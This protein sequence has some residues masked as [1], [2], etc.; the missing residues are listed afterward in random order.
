MG[1][2][3]KRKEQMQ[4]SKMDGGRSAKFPFKKKGQ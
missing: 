3:P 1:T 2:K 4:W